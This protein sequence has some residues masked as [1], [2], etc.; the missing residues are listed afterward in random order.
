V[1]RTRNGERQ[2]LHDLG[3]TLAA[4]RLWMIELRESLPPSCRKPQEGKLK[5]IG[6]LVEDAERCC[7]KLLSR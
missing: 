5:V 7:K 6:R 3:N 2:L 1:A 4:L